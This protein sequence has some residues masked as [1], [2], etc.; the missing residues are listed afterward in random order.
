M[1]YNEIVRKSKLEESKKAIKMQEAQ[2]YDALTEAMSY[3]SDVELNDT[4]GKLDEAAL[5]GSMGSQV[6]KMVKSTTDT[7]NALNEL[8]AAVK[9]DKNFKTNQGLQTLDA[10]I[11]ALIK[12]CQGVQNTLANDKDFEASW[13]A[14]D[15]NTGLFGRNK[16]NGV[17]SANFVK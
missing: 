7:L 15:A 9:S 11:Q 3:M 13:K 10:N 1:D 12:R 2:Y 17:T 14:V 4:L 16:G 8:S 5:F 6:K